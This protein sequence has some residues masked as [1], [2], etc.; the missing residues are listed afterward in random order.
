MKTK[1]VQAARGFTL[2]ELLVVIAIIAILAA[3][4]FPVFAQAREKARQTA[5]LNNLK[6]IGTGT[7][8]YAQDYDENL[9]YPYWLPNWDRW[10]EDGYTWRQR[11]LPYTKNSQIFVCPDYKKAGGAS[12]PADCINSNQHKLAAGVVPS[13]AY[14]GNYGMNAFWTE[15]YEV[16]GVGSGAVAGGPITPLVKATSPSET[17]LVSENS[18]G[19]WALEP[20][21]ASEKAA[22]EP[23]NF[24]A[25]DPPER[26][27]LPDFD[28]C[29]L[30][31]LVGAGGGGGSTYG[32]SGPSLQP[33]HIWTIRHSG[34]GIIGFMDGHTKW[35]KRGAIYGQGT[36]TKRGA[37]YL[38]H[39]DKSSLP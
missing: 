3:I 17:I 35:M 16:P 19:D 6:Q 33:G 15:G 2:I 39:L 37:C 8:M 11:I 36:A 21:A 1:S 28:G 23:Q 38:W 30:Y 26:K 31:P 9:P 27:T 5:C 20:E 22:S 29:A 14:T 34:G 25:N 4:L 13:I 10:C 32:V 12:D 24:T 18:D 7:V